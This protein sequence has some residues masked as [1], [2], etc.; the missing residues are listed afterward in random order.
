MW[1]TCVDK[2]RVV[3]LGDDKHPLLI[4][5][6]TDEFHELSEQTNGLFRAQSVR[7]A[8]QV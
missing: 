7:Q 3:L 6:I 1:P 2:K 8:V 4:R 5:C